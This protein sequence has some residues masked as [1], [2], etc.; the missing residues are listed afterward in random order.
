MTY[1][2]LRIRLGAWEYIFVTVCRM[3]SARTVYIRRQLHHHVPRRYRV[4]WN[5]WATRISRKRALHHATDVCWLLFFV[6]AR[7]A[8]TDGETLRSFK[9]SSWKVI[10]VQDGG[11]TRIS[12]IVITGSGT[13][14]VDYKVVWV[15]NWSWCSAGVPCISVA[16]LCIHRLYMRLQ[17]W[18]L[19]ILRS[20]KL[21]KVKRVVLQVIGRLRLNQLIASRRYNVLKTIGECF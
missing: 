17:S 14:T 15:G 5:R 13:A 8:W 9:T 12:L 1:W 19:L 20:A 11:R 18:S 2:D 10:R 21:L 16:E 7:I 6:V 3:T 4:N